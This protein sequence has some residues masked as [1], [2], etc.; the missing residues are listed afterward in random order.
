MS[1]HEV[2]VVRLTDSR[3]AV[4][5]PRV[6][7]AADGPSSSTFMSVTPSDPTSL[8]PVFTI[9][10]PSVNTGLARCVRW[11]MQGSIT[12]TG[13][14][15]NGLTAANTV[16]FRQFPLQS[17]CSN[18]SAQINDS[19]S[20][21]GS[22]N[23][24]LPGLLRVGATSKSQASS[25][26]MNAV[27]DVFA[28]YLS[29]VGSSSPF[30]P[31]ADGGFTNYAD[32]SRTTGITSIALG[33]GNTTATI[34]FNIWEPLIIQPLNYGEDSHS[35]ALFGL[36][37]LQITASL[38]NVHRMLSLALPGGTTVSSI[39]LTP[40]YQALE[41]NFV[42]PRER[43]LVE[44][45]LEYAYSFAQAQAY[46]ST[47]TSGSFAA[48]TFVS[49]SSNTVEFPVIPSKIIVF[50]TYSESDR[51]NPGE[52]LPDI[53]FPC[54]SI[55]CMMGTKAGLLANA[56][57]SQLWEMSARAGSSMP[58]WLW[59]GE[60]QFGSAVIGASPR[61]AGGPLVIDVAADLSLPDGLSP[62]M[63][64]RIS[65]SVTSATFENQTTRSFTAP[66]ICVIAI[67][68]GI[69]ALKDGAAAIQLGGVPGENDSRFE[70]ATMVE[71][72]E[73]HAN[74]LDGGFGGAT[75]GG[76]MRGWRKFV[77]GLKKVVGIAT[78]LVSM[79]APEATP[80]LMAANT[81]LGAGR[82]QQQGGARMSSSLYRGVR[83]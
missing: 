49:G 1:T 72:G 11:H 58:F 21:L 7:V 34:T 55:N 44:R 22:L 25:M 73:M 30:N 31:P 76:S 40:T 60:A 19:V 77:K 83:M 64:Q 8:N 82:R 71:S 10:V 62:G 3:C 9:Q 70:G 4:K 16:A 29:A 41:C 20:S 24:Y 51:S 43:S 17:C 79:L 13:V 35:K 32:P 37:T 48:A 69:L 39:A 23:Q 18:L 68:D 54:T 47:L 74:T 53:F 63:A 5:A 46:F 50:A 27:P 78:P 61:A 67:T 15:L 6:L 52:S 65:F 28:D 59:R 26:T 12:I 66:R 81:L 2:S 57:Q 45:P 33:G 56:T 36:N 75:L 14:A 80:A 42:T 38:S